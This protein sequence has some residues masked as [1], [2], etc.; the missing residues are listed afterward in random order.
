MHQ[1]KQKAEKEASKK[2][3]KKADLR[4]GGG[5]GFDTMNQ[6]MMADLMGGDEFTAP[7]S[8]E[9]FKRVEEEAYDG[10]EMF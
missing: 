7:T 6:N 1:A 2:K 4:G 9:A 8:G 3:G 5:K 10:D